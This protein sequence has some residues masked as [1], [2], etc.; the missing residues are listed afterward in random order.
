MMSYDTFKMILRLLKTELKVCPEFG[1]MW[2][3]KPDEM[4]RCAKQI[5]KK[6]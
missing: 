6:Q 2:S 4:I 1:K 3:G 5:V